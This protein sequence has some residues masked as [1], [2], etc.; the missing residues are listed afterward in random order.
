MRPR[1]FR[2]FPSQL[3]FAP[4]LIHVLNFKVNPSGE[5]LA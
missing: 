5:G 4:E 3:F 1:V 2:G